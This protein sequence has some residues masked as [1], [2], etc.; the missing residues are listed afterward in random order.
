[1]KVLCSILYIVV[2]EIFLF[3]K[4]HEILN[5]VSTAYKHGQAKKECLLLLMIA[6]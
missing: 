6:E 5:F 3:C 1:M 4:R 2:N